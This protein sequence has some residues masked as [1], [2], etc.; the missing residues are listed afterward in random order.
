MDTPSYPR[1][2]VPVYETAKNDE[3]IEELAEEIK[4]QLKDYDPEKLKTSGESEYSS[5]DKIGFCALAHRNTNLCDRLMFYFGITFSSLFG[6]ALPASFLIFASMVKDLGGGSTGLNEEQFAK[7]YFDPEIAKNAK[8]AGINSMRFNAQLQVYLAF[9]VLFFAGAQQFF[10]LTFAENLA[11]KTKVAYFKAALEKDA[12]YFDENS[13]TEL[14]AKISKETDMIRS[15][16]GDKVGQAFMGLFQ[17]IVG[18][19]LAFTYGAELAAWLLLF[20][21]LI[22]FAAIFLFA[23]VIGGIR[24]IAVAYAQSAGYAEQALHGIKVVHTYGQEVLESNNYK[25]YLTLPKEAQ[26]KLVRNVSLGLAFLLSFIFLYYAYALQMGSKM[27]LDGKEVSPGVKYDSAI[28]LIVLFSIIT[29]SFTIA[30]VA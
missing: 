6:A 29:G 21:P 12:A 9:A 23:G 25:K 11:F 5:G 7:M 27:K 13:A 22:M 8:K 4:D 18:F 1:Q 14:P 28:I 24:E 30:I 20:M 19:A 2:E 10:F 26:A 17:M 3:N 16:M 15:G